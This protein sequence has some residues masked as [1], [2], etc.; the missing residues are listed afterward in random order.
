MNAEL[1]AYVMRALS[2]VPEGEIVEEVTIDA[3]V[4]PKREFGRHGFKPI[5]ESSMGVMTVHL[6]TLEVIEGMLVRKHYDM[7]VEGLVGES[8]E[9]V[10]RR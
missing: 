2:S 7:T 8:V 10:T 4:C 6:S 1:I 3:G 5:D 9:M